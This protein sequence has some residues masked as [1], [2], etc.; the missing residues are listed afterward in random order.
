M[1]SA[2]SAASA[3]QLHLRSLGTVSLV[4]FWIAFT[5]WTLVATGLLHSAEVR[6]AHATAKSTALPPGTKRS[7]GSHWW[8]AAWGAVSSTPRR[9]LAPCSPREHRAGSPPVWW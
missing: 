1:Y 6:R 2:A 9:L 7:V 8:S 4:F 3:K 5:V